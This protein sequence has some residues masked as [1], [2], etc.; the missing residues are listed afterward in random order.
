MKT[1]PNDIVKTLV[2]VLPVILSNIDAEAMRKSTRL[3]NAARL[4]RNIHKRL[5][6]YEDQ[7]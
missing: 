3:G 4:A 5:K 1:V 7:A 2:R 6:L